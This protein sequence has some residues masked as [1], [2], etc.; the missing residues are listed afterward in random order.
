MRRKQGFT[1][2]EL[3]VV[4]VIIGILLGLVSVQMGRVLAQSKETR[5]DTELTALLTVGEQ[6]HLAYPNREAHSQTDLVEVGLLKEVVKSP[7]GGYHYEIE[8]THRRVRAALEKGGQ[9]YEQGAYRAEK[10][11]TRLYLD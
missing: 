6:F 2:I 9:V 3:L 1:L 7:I 8:V 5:I 11:S 10:I 4:L